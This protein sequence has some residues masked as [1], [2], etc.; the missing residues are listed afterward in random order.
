LYFK[1]VGRPLLAEDC[2]LPGLDERQLTR[3]L[4]LKLDESAARDDPKETLELLGKPSGSQILDKSLQIIG[5][6][7][8]CLIGF[9]PLM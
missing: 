2:P 9:M 1:W 3:K 7:L 4:P 6:C 8:E 5:I